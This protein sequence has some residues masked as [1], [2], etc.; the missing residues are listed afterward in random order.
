MPTPPSPSEL[1]ETL[2]GPLADLPNPLPLTLPKRARG[3]A[4]IDATVRPPGS[5]SLTNRALLLA[6]LAG[7]ES[8]LR[9]PLLDADD[10]QRMLAALTLLGA[11]FDTSDPDALTVRGTGGR[12]PIPAPKPPAIPETVLDLNNAGTATRF[13][14]AAALV[15]DHPLVITG[16]ERMR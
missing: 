13:L 7:G 6:A 12:W 8:T 9:R 1:A 10:A 14:T 11:A 16:N 15:A 3:Q 2:S 5:K 4:P